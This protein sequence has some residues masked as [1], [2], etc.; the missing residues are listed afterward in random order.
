M[1]FILLSWI[2]IISI[3][4][5][6]GVSINRL[7][8]IQNQHS[9]I[10][11]VIGFFGISLLTGFYAIRFPINIY[12]QILLVLLCI[13]LITINKTFIVSYV[14][15]FYQKIKA[16]S[17]FSKWLLGISFILILAQCASTP[18]ILDNE[19]YY[20]QT[21]KWLNEYGFVKGLVN[22]HLFLG[23]T[24]GWH[25][26]Q[27]AFNFSFI[28]DRFNDLSGLVLLLGNFYAI[29][30]LNSYI[31]KTDKSKINLVVG[32]FPVFNVF[33]FQFISAPSPDMA[34]YVLSLLV[35]HQFI[36]CYKTYNKSAFLN[37]TILVLFMVFIK[38]TALPFLLLL[39]I[40]FKRYY[41][42]TRRIRI[43]IVSLTFATALIIVVKNWL[44][45]GNPI[46]PLIFI[47]S[48]QS[49]WSLPNTV[50]VYF[51]LYGKAFAYQMSA[52]S[53]EASSWV[54]R[55]K[56]W[57]LASGLHGFF[58][59]AIIGLL[60]IMPII[61]YKFYHKKA[62]WIIY[63]MA[64][65]S[66]ISLLFIAPQYRFYFP[67]FMIFSLLVLALIV[68]HKKSVH[69]LLSFST[70]LALIPLLFEIN[71]EKLTTNTNHNTTSQFKLD[72][73]IKPH[74]NSKYPSTYNTIQVKNLKVNVPNNIDFFWSTGNVPIP[75]INQQQ[76]EYFKTHF[77]IIPQ[78]R[79]DKLKDGFC[80]KQL[81][82]D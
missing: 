55:F 11:I 51:S 54:L 42:Y 45:T 27:S 10:P 68:L 48:L 35:F 37:L 77:Y 14:I 61:I 79:S 21:I 49:S 62:Y 31:A 82:S 46:F 1:L 17:V 57:F 26:L 6:V 76:L 59:K 33:F 65:V 73:L 15:S 80:S 36:L 78:K 44:I 12:F 20:I 30:H 7:F 74:S 75:A 69:V 23:Q 24:S 4:S 64:L 47:D 66:F 58:N 3:S 38:P 63:I 18:F 41:V 5:V 70:L 43:P 39:L 81:N 56:Y 8:N 28:Y 22:L 29:S 9:S 60:L 67:Y 72:Y 53:F 32:L 2:Y 13:V 50:Q 52:D 34:I 40:L 71:N 16:L 19:S 25:I